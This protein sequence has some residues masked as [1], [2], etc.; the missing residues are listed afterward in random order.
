M[1]AQHS[2]ISFTVSNPHTAHLLTIHCCVCVHKSTPP[3]PPPFLTTK[4]V[5]GGFTISV[6]ESWR[7]SKSRVQEEEGPSL[8]WCIC[9]AEQ[10]WCIVWGAACPGAIARQLTCSLLSGKFTQTPADADYSVHTRLHAAHIAQRTYTRTCIVK[11]PLSG[12]Q[13]RAGLF[14]ELLQRIKRLF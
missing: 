11:L 12:N 3:P 5:G 6:T 9:R 4:R 2:C 8:S 14:V 13:M 7:H 1:F 10:Q